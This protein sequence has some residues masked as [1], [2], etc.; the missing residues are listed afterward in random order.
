MQL[1]DVRNIN[2]RIKE[3]YEEEEN[4]IYVIISK[5]SGERGCSLL[6]PTASISSSFSFPARLQLSEQLQANYSPSRRL[7]EG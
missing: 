4:H 1:I 5:I 6:V 2:L 7:R 3:T